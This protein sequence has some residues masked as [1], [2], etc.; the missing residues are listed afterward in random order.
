MSS[1]EWKY[2]PYDPKDEDY[3]G[4]KAVV[5]EE[6]KYIRQ[7]RKNQEL[8]Q[9]SETSEEAGEGII[10]VIVP[11]R[12]EGPGSPWRYVVRWF[13]FNRWGRQKKLPVRDSAQTADDDTPPPHLTGIALSGGGIRS[14]SFCLGVLQALSYAGWLK[15]LDYLSMVSGGGYIGGSLAWLLHKRWKDENGHE[16]PYGLDRKNFPYGSYP[17]VGMAD[18]GWKA[19]AKGAEGVA[20]GDWNVYKGRMLRH[21]RQHARYLTPG[22]GI[23]I[24]SL[25]AVALRNSLFSIFVYGGLLIV[26]FTFAGPFLFGPAM[27]WRLYEY[28]NSCMDWPGAGV[29]SAFGLAAMLTILFAAMAVFY[30]LST[31]ASTGYVLRYWFERWSGRLLLAL[32]IVLVLGSLPLIYDWINEAGRSTPTQTSSFKISGEASDSGEISLSG[33]ID[34]PKAEA[35]SPQTEWRISAL[36]NNLAA[37]L[38]GL[39]TLLG[40]I[41][42][43]LAFFQNGKS[44]KKVPTGLLVAVGSFALIFGL[45]LLAYHFAALLRVPPGIAASEALWLWPV[46]LDDSRL[47]S[48]SVVIGIAVLLAIFLRLPN[49]NYL[50]IHRYYRDRL[51]ETFTPDLPDALDPN[52]QVPGG[53]KSANRAPLFKMLDENSV[54]ADAGPY[55][56]IN[57][58]IVLV[59]SQI[60]KFRGRGGDNFILTPKYCGSNATGWCAT[61]DSPYKGMTLPTAMAISGAAINS[62]TGGGGEGLTRNPWLSFLMG[63]FNIRLGYWAENP[64]PAKDRVDRIAVSL[65][66]PLKLVPEKDQE[67]LARWFMEIVWHGLF[68]LLRWPLNQLTVM[69]HRMLNLGLCCGRNVPNAFYPGLSELYLRKNLDENSRMV[70][71]SDGGHFENLGLY[72]L[73]RRRLKLIIVC[74]GAAD[75][76]FGFDDLANAMGK[77]RAD[78]GTLIEIDCD[79]AELLTPMAE[80]ASNLEKRM[81]YAKK[82]Y[83]IA[84]IIY[85][86]KA[87]GTLLYVTTSFFK[88][89]YADLYAYRKAHQEFPDQPTG[90]QFFDEKQFEAYREL[91]YQTAYRMMCDKD[92]Q[93]HDDVKGTVGIPDI[94]CKPKGARY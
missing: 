42:T 21:L 12:T 91:G 53:P 87:R 66:R 34:K 7:R 77:V 72:E 33:K 14:A 38:G 13:S 62:N 84:N 63:F 64:T 90:D 31:W 75:A 59:T 29:N 69:W 83:L 26:L 32:A 20:A 94:S 58:N 24:M 71:L 55:P 89:L 92:V 25:L 11:E 60:P 22:N 67:H 43:A 61:K 30:A 49:L 39:S 18:E 54:S 86:D 45:L 3:F 68:C 2:S 50:S 36:R 51:M 88:E 27:D 70:Q 56:I 46:P 4:C 81:A 85:N 47:R 9:A 6:W 10:G 65:A 19:S 5:V 35:E 78:F 8:E 41:A 37:T 80:G 44:K 52:G 57:S 16:I 76:A 17:M 15:R 82:G 73:I 23:N 28:F 74:D 93:G 48:D 40:A 79:D 1:H